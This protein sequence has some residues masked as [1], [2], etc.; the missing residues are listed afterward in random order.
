MHKAFNGPPYGL[1][2]ACGE[3]SLYA[4]RMVKGGKTE[5]KGGPKRRAAREQVTPATKPKRA[6]APERKAAS[7][8]VQAPKGVSNPMA[9][10]IALAL[11]DDDAACAARETE[12]REP[13]SPW[14]LAARATGTRTR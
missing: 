12:L 7:R 13:P 14:T 3:I 11:R 9:V 6:K 5:K 4:A 2:S 10:A 1:R 8:G